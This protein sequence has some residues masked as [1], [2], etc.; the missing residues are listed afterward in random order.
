MRS[1]YPFRV[2]YLPLLLGDVDGLED[3]PEDTPVEDATK[4][5]SAEGVNIGDNEPVDFSNNQ[6]EDAVEDQEN[7][8]VERD[9]SGN[10]VSRQLSA[11]NSA[12]GSDHQGADLVAPSGGGS[13]RSSLKSEMLSARS[14]KSRNS[15]L[16]ASRGVS[17]MSA[18][19]AA[20]SRG[21]SA[22]SVKSGA[23]SRG[24]SA[25]SVKSGAGSRG[26]S[27]LSVKSGSGQGGSGQSSRSEKQGSR[28]GSGQ[29]Q[30]G[31]SEKSGSRHGSD[32]ASA[33][34]A[35]S[36]RGSDQ[37]A[38]SRTATP[39]DDN[40]DQLSDSDKENSQVEDED[41]GILVP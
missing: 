25:L 26:V 8:E 12:S 13:R 3:A 20:A 9:P 32:Q 24:V 1:F 29:S 31:L 28:R 16:P 37:P 39:A 15:R 41:K 30:A 21:V 4:E 17:A 34:S 38:V 27:A 7:R 14:A 10:G 33:I 36:R 19:S 40:K 23:G 2:P 22:L 6:A 35:G 5:E 18:K 11:A